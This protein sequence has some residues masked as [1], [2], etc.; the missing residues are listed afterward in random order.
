M[1]YSEYF[2][3]DQLDT[4]A[5]EDEIAHAEEALGVTFPDDLRAFWLT[6]ATFNGQ[7]LTADGGPGPYLRVLHPSSVTKMGEACVFGRGEDWDFGV[8]PGH[9]T[10]WVDVERGTGEELSELGATFVGFLESLRGEF[11]TENN[12]LY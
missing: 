1:S 11:E 5:T 12:R 10:R 3:S 2:A 8:V 7:V 6:S 4:P 9:P